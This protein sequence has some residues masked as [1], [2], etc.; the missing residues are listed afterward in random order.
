MS[1]TWCTRCVYPTSSAVSLTFDDSGVCSG[2]KVAEANQVGGE[3]DWESRK[4]ALKDIIAEH[5]KK[6]D[7]YDCIVP[8][9]GGKDSYFQTHFI[10]NELGLNPLLVTYYGNNYLPEGEYNLQRMADVFS[11]DHLIFKPSVETLRKLNRLC[12]RLMGDMNWHAHC[13]IYTV[14][15]R[16]AVR[17]EVP[18]VVYGEHGRTHVGGMFSLDDMVELTARHVREHVCRGFTWEDMIE[19]TEGLTKQDVAWTVYPSD[20][21]LFDLGFRGLFMNFFVPWK[22]NDHTELV[23]REYG[24]QPREES[25]D[26]TY[27]KIS[28]LDD[29]HENGI[30]D[31]LKFVK[32]G[33]GRCT[34]HACKDIR[35]GAMTREE[36]IE[37]VRRHDHVKPRDLVRWL[38]YV[39]M[40][41][42]EFDAIADSFR[43]PR[44]WWRD[45]AGN[46]EKH[47]L[48]DDAE[49]RDAK[50]QRRQR[51]TN[52]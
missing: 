11:V 9:S 12:Y 5:K 33:Y 16:T 51:G 45:D 13:G 42:A 34:D 1:V 24:W 37:L 22:P 31:Y 8:V 35:D 4:Q 39:G 15:V 49:T 28:N 47:H 30:H 38:E 29:M 21:E 26:R 27:R 2:C 41:E 32:F 44:V 52:R 46:W 48:W 23:I 18:V 36:A 14:P 43:D 17:Y 6:D 40:D 19:E 10:K 20:D 7:N 3:I 25:F 50:E